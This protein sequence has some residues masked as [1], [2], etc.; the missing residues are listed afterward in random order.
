MQHARN[1]IDGQWVDSAKKT[2]SLNPSTGKVLGTFADAGAEEATAAIAAAR[3]AFDTTDWARDRN[4]RARALFEMADHLEA[5]RDEFV[6][7][8]AR[9]NGKIL[10]EAAFEIDLTVPKLRYYAALALSDHGSSGEVRPGLYSMT[11]REGA[12][13]AAVIAPWNSPVV[14]AVRSFA[15]ALAAGCTVAMKLPGQTGLVNGL[16]SELIAQTK[17]LPAGVMNV[18]TESGNDGAPLLITS[19]DVDVISY[20]GSTVVGR[21][22][23]ANAAPTLKAL[24]LELGGK[25]PMIVFDDADLDLAVPVLTKAITTFTGQFCMT[26]SRIL[27][28][29]GVADEFRLRMTASLKAVKVGPGDDPASEMGPLIDE[30]NARRVEGVVADAAAYAKLL[31]QGK[32]DGAFLHPSL[33]EVQDVDSPIVQQ[34]VFGPVATFEVFETEAEAVARANATEFGLAASLWTRDVDRPL[35]VG[36]EIQAGTVWTN[37]W[38]IVHDMFEEGGFKQS[39]MGRLNGMRGLEEFQETK[40]YVHAAPRA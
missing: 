39:G 12:G 21:L 28:Q 27:V 16:L 36:R 22:I 26:G 24:S 15:P 30:R 13:V 33:I 19:P 20:T 38:A 14:L 32:R 9:E 31:V 18:F 7:L 4:L 40:H 37:T 17:N 2:E 8:L 3:R 35:R 34:E 1:F 11:L 25:S 23:A 10:G 5:R 6:S 29:S